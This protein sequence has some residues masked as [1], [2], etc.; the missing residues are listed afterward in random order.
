[1]KWLDRYIRDLRIK[2]AL[3]FIKDGDRLLDVGCFDL[4][5]LRLAKPRVKLAVGIDPLAT[6]LTE[7]NL[8]VIRGLVGAEH[9]NGLEPASFDCITMLAV[10][11]HVPDAP[12]FAREIAR[13]LAPGGRV[14]ITVPD[15]KVDHILA[16]L[17]KLHLI[18]GM[19][20]EEHHGYDVKQTRPMFEAAGLKMTARRTFELGLNNLY[21]F[22]SP[23]VASAPATVVTRPVSDAAIAGVPR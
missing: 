21:V 4:T 22:E 20:L 18:H 13:L 19:S 10:L 11:E 8:R 3:P 17:H 12:G 16:V 1:M 9:D 23:R 14:V 6:P 5:M 2:Q 15:A 7:G